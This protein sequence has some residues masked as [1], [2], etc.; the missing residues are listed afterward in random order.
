MS[1]IAQAE[2]LALSL[3]RKERGELAS[4]LIASLGTPFD[5]E[6]EDI[7]ELSIRR[8][9]E[10]DEHPESVVTEEEFW[11]GIEKYRRA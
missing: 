3:S 6:D 11:A 1:V 7:V 4:K 9:K 8:D 10:M 5:A 2:E